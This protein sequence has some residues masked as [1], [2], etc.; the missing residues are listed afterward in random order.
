MEAR[1]VRKNNKSE[2]AANNCSENIPTTWLQLLNKK[3]AAFHED[4]CRRL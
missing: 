3:S 1:I 2:V 4:V